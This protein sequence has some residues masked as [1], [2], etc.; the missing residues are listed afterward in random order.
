M[1]KPNIIHRR[2]LEPLWYRANEV[3]RYYE[4]AVNCISA[5]IAADCISV[6]HSKHPKA[7][8]FCN[9]C[10]RYHQH[11]S[12]MASYEYPCSYI[13]RKA[14]T[15]ARKFGGSLIYT[16]PVGFSFWTS[17]FFAG[18]L[19]AG[20]FI[21]SVIP[22]TGKEKTLDKLF[23]VCRGEISR[24]EIARYIEEV[25]AKTGGEIQALA[26][27]MML[28]AQQVTRR[29][30]SWNNTPEQCD[31]D[32]M[33]RER[34]LV[35]ILRRGDNAEAL[36]LTRELLGSLKTAS[37]GNL[38]RFKL[39]VIEL[40]VMLSRAGANPENRRELIEANSRYLKRIEETKTAEEISEYMCMIVEQMSVKIFSFRGMRHASALRK[41]ERFIRENYERKIN[42]REIA[43]AS[44][45]S[46][47]YFSTIFKDEMGENLSGYLNRLRVDRASAML[48]ETEYPI[49][50][51]SAACG[52]EDQSWFSK[53]FKNYT[54]FSPWK[55][56]R[57]G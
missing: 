12:K 40:V 11:A 46:A 33:D 41:A 49:S 23:S 50:K 4:K 27:M 54:G 48:R 10:K 47:P 29:T 18:E 42:L 8:F 35:A 2:D 15:G 37:A 45:L 32:I 5:V 1:E 16:C 43:D 57:L 28:C 20:A 13:H 53:T 56:R 34:L 30:P 19:F 21:S 39:R 3:V 24:A 17:P 22:I 44:G 26:R 7:V 9:I 51:I 55:Y 38:D 14:A 52:F 6:E 36:G 31:S 25:P